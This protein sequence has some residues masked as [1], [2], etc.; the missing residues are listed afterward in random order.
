MATRNL[1]AASSAAFERRVNRA[2]PPGFL[3]EH[4]LADRVRSLAIVL[5]WGLT[6][7]CAAIAL[8]R[9]SSDRPA[10]VWA[11][12]AVA[13]VAAWRSVAPE[14]AHGTWAVA[15][16]ALEVAVLCAA[17]DVS[18]G[19]TSPYI[20]V[21]VATVLVAGLTWGWLG[22]VAG[23][24]AFVGVPTIT[25][26]T[27]L[28]SMTAWATPIQTAAIYLLF[29]IVGAM[30]Y[31]SVQESNQRFEPTRDDQ[32]RLAAANDLLAT[33][34]GV[35]TSLSAPLDLVEV[36][37]AARARCA[38]FSADHV[39]L[40]LSDATGDGWR[41]EFADG[42]RI[43]TAHSQHDVPPLFAAALR[44]VDPVGENNFAKAQSNGWSP[45]S[46]S[47]MAVALRA[48]NT[49][50]GVLT[51]E[52]DQP[53][54][55]EHDDLIWL[56]GL[57]SNLALSIDNAQWFAR[58]RSLGAEAER[59]R[60]ARDL[61]DRLAQSLAYVAI[62]LERYG[63]ANGASEELDRLTGVVRDVVAE[64]R[65]TLYE[66][67]VTP[68]DERSLLSVLREYTGKYSDRT[69]IAVTLR[70]SEDTVRFARPIEVELWRI[71][72][73]SLT[74]VERHAGASR[75]WITVTNAGDRA[76]VEIRDN[77]KGFR[78]SVT[79]RDRY[80]LVGMRE[81]ADAIN[82]HLTIDS[83][84]GAGTCVRVEVEVPQ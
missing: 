83:E 5:R 33:L 36:V 28:T 14:T 41:T 20:Y 23:T 55:I 10:M 25:T 44:S 31:R 32:T 1:D 11:F 22:A 74:N 26:M 8:S 78:P 79:N 53:G 29:G 3:R 66:L 81:R 84:P 61:H 19:W 9:P 70:L 62:E 72:Q 75:A 60:L 13:V 18:G 68:N 39:T 6:I 46:R 42:V 4:R 12:V 7:L 30:A 48:R 47:G 82:A 59:N 54:Q 80:G 65:S 50:I 64:L 15:R 67:R 56:G 73:E 57:A 45:M 51:V 27:H 34:H 76:V 40:I 63:R 71:L 38:R 35:A 2:R 52:Y 43:P 58:I 77:G 49:I 17:I 37:T 16:T 24:V 21:P 69:G